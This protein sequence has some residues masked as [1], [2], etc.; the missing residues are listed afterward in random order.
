[1]VRGAIDSLTSGEARGWAY[2]PD[3]ADPVMV[4]AVLNHEIVGQAVADLYRADLAAA[5]VGDGHSGYVMKFLRPIDPLYF[6][7]I[8]VKL[9]GGDAELPRASTLGFG[10]F[11]SALHHAWPASG[12]HRS[13]LGGVWTDR[14]DAAAL[15]AGKCAIGQIPPA[16]APALG[17]LIRTGFALRDLPALPPVTDWQAALPGC[18]AALLDQPALLALLRAV[19]E[20]N[21][22]LVA[23]DWAAAETTALEQPSTAIASPSPA[24]CLALVLPFGAGVVLDI[25][26]DGHVLAE[27]TPD[28]VSRWAGGG[29]GA[30][31]AIVAGNGLLDC[32][33]LAP[34]RVAVLGPGTLYRLRCPPGNAALRLLCLPARLL[35]L[36]IA[37][38]S[39]RREILCA[40]GA[41]LWL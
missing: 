34:D 31:A 10:A 33:T 8:A 9:D 36:A 16:L 21:P 29:R 4:Q 37:T 27:F 11:F 41:R 1:M 28:G 24:E 2:A 32:H 20:D 19:L 26:R 35:P 17:E 15:L 22:L 12:R 13:V 6:P 5:G 30:A 18:A 14:T 40:G 3:R 25:L 39:L 38:D 7:F 23:A